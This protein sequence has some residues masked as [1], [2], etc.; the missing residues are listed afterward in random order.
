MLLVKPVFSRYFS[1]FLV[2]TPSAE[3]IEG[4]IGTL[5]SFQILFVSRA[6]FSCYVI[7]SVSVLE[8][9]RVKRTAISITG[10]VLFSIDEHLIRS[11]AIYRSA[12]YYTDIEI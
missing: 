10:S 12:N 1:K 3:M 2:T 6:K 4:D 9:L 5:L 8:R 11:V 7:L